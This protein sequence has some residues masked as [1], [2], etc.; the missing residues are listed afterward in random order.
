M[1]EEASS[2][3]ERAL[4]FPL[5]YHTSL[6]I[7]PEAGY[8]VYVTFKPNRRTT[9]YIV[10]RSHRGSYVTRCLDDGVVSKA[11]R[12]IT[13][14]EFMCLQSLVDIEDSLPS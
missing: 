2:V 13:F 12:V 7:S 6:H 10:Y 5:M 1:F 9:T 14:H 3:L 4:M 8:C 11:S